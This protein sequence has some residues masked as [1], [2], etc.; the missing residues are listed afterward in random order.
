MQE[1]CWFGSILPLDRTVP[2]LDSHLDWHAAP[3]LP[4]HLGWLAPTSGLVADQLFAP[5]GGTVPEVCKGPCKD[6]N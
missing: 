4:F 1:L 2:L 5:L 6:S 3:P